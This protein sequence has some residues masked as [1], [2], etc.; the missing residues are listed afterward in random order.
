MNRLI[1]PVSETFIKTAS[2]WI[3]LWLHCCLL[4]TNVASPV[5]S[6]QNAMWPLRKMEAVITW[7]V[8][9]RTAKLS[10]AGSAWVHGNPMVQPGENLKLLSHFHID[11]KG[12]TDISEIYVSM[13][14][15]LS[16]ERNQHSIVRQLWCDILL[17]A[18]TF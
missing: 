6:A 17:M 14:L 9:T 12:N 15:L 16:G 3:P 4:K 11:K 5:R 10:S 8:G 7:F 13:S 2:N 1:V 18:V